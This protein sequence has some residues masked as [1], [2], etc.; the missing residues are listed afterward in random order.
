V[1]PD[2]AIVLAFVVIVAIATAV[3]VGASYFNKNVG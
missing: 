2:V 3:I 1:N